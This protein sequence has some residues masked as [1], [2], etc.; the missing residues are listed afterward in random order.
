MQKQMKRR[1]HGSQGFS[2]DSSTGIESLTTLLC[3]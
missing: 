1:R 3:S 2:M